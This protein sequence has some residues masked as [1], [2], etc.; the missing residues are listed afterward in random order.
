MHT[1]V[2]DAK[3]KLVYMVAVA[4]ERNKLP[5]ELQETRENSDQI[6]LHSLFCVARVNAVTLPMLPAHFAVILHRRW[7]CSFWPLLPRHCC[8]T[9]GYRF[10]VI[11][12]LHS[13]LAMI[14][15][16]GFSVYALYKWG[17]SGSTNGSGYVNQQ[18]EYVNGYTRADGPYVPGYRRTV[19]DGTLLNN[20][21]TQGS[22]NPWT[23]QP[24]YVDPYDR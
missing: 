5:R 11:F 20:Y 16:S 17:G 2:R 8:L 14:A 18:Y 10:A 4:F 24:G 1:R 19:G 21:S 12:V 9:K 7:V 15:L 6:T 13:G 22:I 23:G 3:R